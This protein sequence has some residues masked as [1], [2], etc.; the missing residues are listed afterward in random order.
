MRSERR[1]D[2]K[3]CQVER[4]QQE[5]PAPTEQFRLRAWRE[6]Q[7]ALDPLAPPKPLPQRKRYH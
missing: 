7:K 5:L 2:D 1:N 3:G 4:G 6:F